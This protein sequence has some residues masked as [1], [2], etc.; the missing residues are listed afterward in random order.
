MDRK[1][2]MTNKQLRT[3]AAAGVV[4]LALSAGARGAGESLV[5]APV[6]SSTATGTASFAAVVEAV[7]QTAVAAQVA[8]SVTEIRVKA[9]DAVRAG[10]VLVR[11]DARAAEQTAASGDAQVQACLLYTSDAADE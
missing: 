1:N 4:A 11:L 10:Q 6:A 8:G 5:T 9:G 7:R 3:L 2:G